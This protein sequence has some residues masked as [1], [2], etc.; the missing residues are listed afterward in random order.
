VERATVVA[1]VV[2]SI[3]ALSPWDPNRA[4]E[5]QIGEKGQFKG[6]C[7]PAGTSTNDPIVKP[8][9]TTAHL[10]NFWGNKGVPANPEVD[11]VEEMRQQ[12]TS[13]EDGSQDGGGVTRDNKSSYWL[14][15]PYING[16]ALQPVGSGF[17]YSSKGGLDP[18]KTKVTPFG[19]KIIAKHQDIAPSEKQA[20]EVDIACD[21]GELSRDQQVPDGR[22]TV[23]GAGKCKPGGGIDI[24]IT[25]PECLDTATLGLNQ[26]RAFRAIGR[27]TDNAYCKEGTRQIPTL[28]EFFTYRIPASTPTYNGPS[29]LGVADSGG[30]ILPWQY[31]HGD[32]FNAEDLT[33][34]VQFCIN[35]TNAGDPECK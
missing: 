8:A 32:Y 11:T 2:M 18:T 17:Y 7:A 15:Q 28:Q 1:V 20:A 16:V 35:A 31:I 29:S 34:E 4:A 26:Q 19:L 3:V 24:A 14:P 25:F 33:R 27:G 6:Q 13:C 22:N 23:P 9:A 21:A 30:R 12:E 5:A 10:H